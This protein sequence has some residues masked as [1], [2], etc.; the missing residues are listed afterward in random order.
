MRLKKYAIEVY[1]PGSRGMDVVCYIE[2]DESFLPIQKGDLLNPRVWETSGAVNSEPSQFG[3]ILRVT[4]I[5]H[6]IIQREPG[7]SQHKLGIFTEQVDDV[8][9]SRPL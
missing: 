1:A 5:E 9:E 7:F 3:M 4:G 2:S 6:F 8:Q